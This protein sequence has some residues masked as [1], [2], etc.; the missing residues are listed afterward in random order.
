MFHPRHSGQPSNWQAFQRSRP[1][2]GTSMTA[3]TCPDLCPTIR[4]LAQGGLVSDQRKIFETTNSLPHFWD[5]RTLP[6]R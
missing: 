3:S 4:G 2:T 1:P 6:A 5:D